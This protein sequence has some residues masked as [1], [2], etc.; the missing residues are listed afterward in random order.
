VVDG[1]KEQNIFCGGHRT[2]DRL[3]LANKNVTHIL[4][5]LGHGFA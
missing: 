3:G 1:G 2:L 4:D 5:I